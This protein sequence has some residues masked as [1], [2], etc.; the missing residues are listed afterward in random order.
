M[1][2]TVYNQNK[3]QR[4]S[5]QSVDTINF[6]ISLQLI[7][8]TYTQY[9]HIN[10]PNQKAFMSLRFVH[11]CLPF[12]FINPSTESNLLSPKF[13]IVPR[14][15]KLHPQNFA[16]ISWHNQILEDPLPLL[17]TIKI[18]SLIPTFQPLSFFLSSSTTIPPY[19]SQ[20]NYHST[21]TSHCPCMR[22]FHP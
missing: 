17:F 5:R 22:D 4:Q 14:H 18:I 2:W 21:I 3:S 9:I 16:A 20:Q 11:C 8:N 13:P 10:P 6:R 15:L 19:I 7:L 12:R 1:G